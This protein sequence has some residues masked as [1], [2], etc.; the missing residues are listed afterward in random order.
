MEGQFY[1]IKGVHTRRL[2]SPPF[3]RS[4]VRMLFSSYLGYRGSCYVLATR[5]LKAFGL[6]VGFGRCVKPVFLVRL[7]WG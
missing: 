5:G 7:S 3:L 6:Q 1:V 2:W 4:A